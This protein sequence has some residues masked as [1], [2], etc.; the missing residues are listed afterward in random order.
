MSK[1]FKG[2]VFLGLCVADTHLLK[3]VMYRQRGWAIWTMNDFWNFYPELRPDR[4]YQIHKDADKHVDEFGHY[5]D[6]SGFSEYCQK[7]GVNDIITNLSEESYGWYFG[8]QPKQWYQSTVNYMFVDAW[9][10]IESG[11]IEPRIALEGMPFISEGE[12]NRQRA[13]IMS[14]IE[15]SVLRGIDTV[16]PHWNKWQEENL[17]VDWGSLTDFT[18]YGIVE[19]SKTVLKK[20]INQ[21][22]NDANA[23]TP[24]EEW[25]MFEE[26]MN[27]PKL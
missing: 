15:M 7:I 9:R 23:F 3:L 17:T 26:L 14:A 6:C 24:P 11:E 2:I 8:K 10:L 21:L 19:K 4:A 12:R 18:V 20:S 13:F 16:A 1:K 22:V 27:P 5:R 25:A